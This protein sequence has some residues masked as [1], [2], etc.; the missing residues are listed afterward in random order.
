VPS[1]SLPALDLECL[2][3]YARI[4]EHSGSGIL[5][6]KEEETVVRG[7]E[8]ESSARLIALRGLR[9]QAG[10]RVQTEGPAAKSKK[11]GTVVHGVGLSLGV[12][13]AHEEQ[14]R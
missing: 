7:S 2:T 8:G 6:E 5:L 12:P 9:L 4:D 1:G 13:G 10:C 14:E 11:L 3:S